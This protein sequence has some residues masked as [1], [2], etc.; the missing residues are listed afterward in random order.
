MS[1]VSTDLGNHEGKC[2]SQ[3]PFN[4]VAL[5][6]SGSTQTKPVLDLLGVAKENAAYRTN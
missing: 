3:A 2:D 5:P 4:A 1:I 6:G